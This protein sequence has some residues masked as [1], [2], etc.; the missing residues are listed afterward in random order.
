MDPTHDTVQDSQA[1][2]VNLESGTPPEVQTKKNFINKKLLIFIGITAI[3]A[4]ICLLIAFF[5]MSKKNPPISNTSDTTPT[6]QNISPSPQV[7]TEEKKYDIVL[8]KGELVQVPD[9][10]ISFRFDTVEIPDKNCIDCLSITEISYVIDGQEE[11][12]VFRCGGIAGNCE[13]TKDVG[14]FRIELQA[15]NSTSVIN[16]SVY[17][18]K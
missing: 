12:M 6:Q 8:K 1:Q 13:S 14:R 15:S 5:V 10:N 18:K 16:A 2:V 4:M 11:K 3:I 17:I 7:V 9:E